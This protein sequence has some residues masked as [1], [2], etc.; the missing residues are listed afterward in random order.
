[1]LHLQHIVCVSV[2]MCVCLSVCVC[3]CA[4]YWNTRWNTIR[5][6]I[7]LFIYVIFSCDFIFWRRRRRRRRRK[8]EKFLLKRF[9]FEIDSDALD[10]QTLL[11]TSQSG[12][13]GFI[14]RPIGACNLHGCGAS[15]VGILFGNG[16]ALAVAADCCV[17]FL[18]WLLIMIE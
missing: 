10:Q 13:N 6:L 9:F 2:C 14:T 15:S 16:R 7:Y 3:V 5:S 11:V 12:S 4:L 17:S 1:M 18:V 8:G